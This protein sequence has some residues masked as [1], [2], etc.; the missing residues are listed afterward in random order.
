MSAPAETFARKWAAPVRVE[1]PAPE[2]ECRLAEP[3][4]VPNAAHLM[5]R[6]AQSAGWLVLFTY[7]RGTMPGRAMKVV[8][9]LA[10][11]MRRPPLGACAIWI[12][13]AFDF[14]LRYERCEAGIV[15]APMASLELSR[16]LVSP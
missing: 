5:S 7:A 4:E 8:D 10:L 14:G 6:K 9:S 2:V 15:W 3:W 1:H 11:R 13:G 12:D 16:W